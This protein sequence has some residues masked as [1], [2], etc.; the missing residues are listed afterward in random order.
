MWHTVDSWVTR[1]MQAMCTEL[2]W[3]ITYPRRVDMALLNETVGAMA[4]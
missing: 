1:H 4:G 2:L 3:V